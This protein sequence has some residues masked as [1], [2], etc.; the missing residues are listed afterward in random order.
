M[1]HNIKHAFGGRVLW[2]HHTTC[3]YTN[4]QNATYCTPGLLDVAIG[5]ECRSIRH[6]G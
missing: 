5:S 3:I 6:S 2:K 4:P 1:Q